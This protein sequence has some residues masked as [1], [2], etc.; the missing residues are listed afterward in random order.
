[1]PNILNNKCA[2]YLRFSSN[3][4]HET[5]IEM[6]RKAV[7]EYA[8]KNN[9]KIV[10]EYAD[11]A[12]TATTAERKNF[13][14][15]IADAKSK[16]AWNTIL[17][18]DYS[19][20]SR[21]N[22]DA[23]FYKGLLR[24]SGITLIS[25]TQPFYND[26]PEATLME[27]MM[28]VYNDYFSRKLSVTTHDGMKNTA[29]KGLH[30]GGIPP[31]GY[32]VVEQKYIINEYEA[33]TVRKIFDMYLANFS[34]TKMCEILNAEGRTTKSGQLF[35]RN[36]FGSIL[37]QNKYIGEFIWN[38]SAA[39]NSQHKRNSHAFKPYA[40]QVIIEDSVP[41]I[42]SADVF[43][44]AQEK[45]AENKGG[46]EGHGKHHYMLSGKKLMK[47]A[48]CGAFLVGGTK[49]NRGK[50][51]RYYQCPNHKRN[52]CPTKDIPAE[53]VEYFV[54]RMLT[55]NLMNQDY[56]EEYNRLLNFYSKERDLEVELRGIEMKITNVVKALTEKYSESLSERLEVLEELKAK[57][58]KEL[59][60]LDKKLPDD[61]DA[62]KQ[63]QGD[64][65][66]AL[67]NSESLEIQKLLTAVI[68]EIM[69]NNDDI[70]VACCF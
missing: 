17:V 45:R 39:K 11:R 49:S 43:Y 61:E 40:E 42:I 52:G 53:H 16:P 44:K 41:P 58:L 57:K 28:F 13:Q 63:V 27:N 38:K 10:A 31:L 50:I 64:F 6:Q 9:Y 68:K 30:C 66:R 19:R 36:S 33:E 70:R 21:N 1:M 51:V 18:Y 8:Q 4:Q 62:V 46:V 25:V 32:D 12:L 54:A 65:A 7:K 5:S 3:N 24:D 20:Y 48:H 60:S 56:F 47:C 23:L 37:S 15:M 14:R 22:Y 35:T 69:I 34:Y 2:I 67:M 59:E 29:E 55:S 26:S